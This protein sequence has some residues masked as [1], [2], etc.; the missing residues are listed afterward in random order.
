MAICTPISPCA[1]CGESLGDT[2]DIIGFPDLVPM[3]SDFG[4]FYDACAHAD[5][6]KSWARRDEFVVYFNSLVD[7]SRL[8]QSWNL[9]VMPSGYVTYRKAL[10]RGST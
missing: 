10:E 1:V 6:L 9:V 2:T 8:D 3:F 5:C 4:N 7:A